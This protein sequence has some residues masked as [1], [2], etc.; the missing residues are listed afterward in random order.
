MK[1]RSIVD[2]LETLVLSGGDHDGCSF[3]VLPWERRF[4]M[5]RSGNRVMPP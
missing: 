2:Y 4:V 5:E 1:P 3:Q